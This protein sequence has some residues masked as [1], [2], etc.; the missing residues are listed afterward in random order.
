LIGAERWLGGG[1]HKNRSLNESS[2]AGQ[3]RLLQVSFSKEVTPHERQQSSA[4]SCGVPSAG[5]SRK[6]LA[7]R[8]S[9]TME[10]EFCL[11]ALEEALH[12]YGKPEIFNTSTSS[13]FMRILKEAAGWTTSSSSGY[14]VH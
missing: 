12:A 14:G 4:I 5:S 7:W 9:N 1:E 10:T 8:L 13:R 11:D 2:P 6:V 3:A